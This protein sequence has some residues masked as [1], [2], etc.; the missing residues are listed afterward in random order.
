MPYP[1]EEPIRNF[2]GL[3]KPLGDLA[4]TETP[5]D[6]SFVS[7]LPSVSA[8]DFDEIKNRVCAFR[9]LNAKQCLRSADAFIIDGQGTSA[10]YY[11][12]E[13]KNQRVN[14]IQSVRDPDR[15]E[16]MQKAFDSLSI[17]AMTFGRNIPMK[18]LQRHSTFIVVYPRQDF[19]ERF[20]AI[21]NEC[22]NGRDHPLWNLDKL[23]K[24]GFFAGIKTIDE[25][26]LAAMSLS[27]FP[28]G[29]NQSR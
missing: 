3:I 29:A 4:V 8:Y 7:R 10:Q 25:E 2:S 15:N 9:S 6:A 14:N 21:L 12:I 11:F 18:E 28:N 26:K 27:L 1:F 16:L 17:L 19:S 13:F 24:N 5:F 23:T 22:A 20:N